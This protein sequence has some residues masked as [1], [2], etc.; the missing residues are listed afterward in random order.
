MQKVVKLM[1]LDY[2]YVYVCVPSTAMKGKQP[3]DMSHVLPHPVLEVGSMVQFGNPAQ[4]GVIKDFK[5]NAYNKCAIIE[6]VSAYTHMHKQTTTYVD[7]IS[8][9]GVLISNFSV[10]RYPLFK[11][12]ILIANLIYITSC[13]SHVLHI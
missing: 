9:T 1:L 5:N 12:L 3:D 2:M 4:Y 6:T 13:F 10:F 7:D 8:T 11:K